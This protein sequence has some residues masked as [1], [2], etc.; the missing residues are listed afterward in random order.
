MTL[1]RKYKLNYINRD[2]I[3]PLITETVRISALYIME[4]DL[5]EIDEIMN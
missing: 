1:C 2:D 3:I 4:M 5:D